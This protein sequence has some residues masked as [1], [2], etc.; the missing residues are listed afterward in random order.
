M[1]KS[2]KILI[3]SIFV[4]FVLN[5][6]TGLA[7]AE[8]SMAEYNCEPIFQVNAVEPNI[9]II[10]DNSGSMNEQAYTGNYVHGTKYYG[11]FEPYEKYTYGSNVFTRNAGGAWD[12]NFLNWLTMRRVDVARKV[13]MGGLATSR[14]GGG[15][16]TN[17]G[18]TPAQNN[19][20]FIKA[21]DDTDGVTPFAAG[22]THTYLV[23]GGNFCIDDDGDGNCDAVNTTYVIKVDK[24]MVTYPDEAPNFD[25]DG[26]L[27]GV[28]QKVSSK[29]RW[30]NEFF[31]YGTGN[32]ESGG[33]I[34]STI[35]TNMASL[36]TDLQNQACNTW[37]PLAEAYYV[38]VQYFKQEDP[39]AGLHY[40]NNAAPNANVGDDPFYNGTEFVHC[41]KG[42]VILLTDGASTMDMM[43][44]D[45]LKD[46]DNDNNDP[47]TYSDSGSDYLDDIALY[48][49]TTDLRSSTVG[50][51]ELDG[52]QNLILYT[53][54]AFG[55]DPSAENL[56]KNA[57]KNGGFID[58]NGNN[59][60][61]LQEEWDEDNDGD[62][63]TYYKA[64]N[65]YKLESEL[66]KA[67]NDIL[68]KAASGTAVSVLATSG[69]GEANLVQ[70]YFRPVVTSGTKDI[71]WVGYLQSLWVDSYGN[72]REDTVH[73]YI[74]NENEDDIIT[75]FTDPGT[76]DTMIKR[77]PAGGG[78]PVEETLEEISPLWEAGK[79]LAQ[80]NPGDR[81][82][83]TYIDINED[84]VVDQAT[85]VVGFHTG[86][87]NSIKPYLGVKDGATWGHL[88]STHNDRVD[89]VI[90]YIRG[91]EIAGLRT[92]TID[93]AVWKLGDIVHSTPVSIAKPPDNFHIIYSDE[94]YQG[95]YDANKNRETVVYVGANDGML[96]AF[97][98]G[99]YDPVL[100]KYT[101]AGAESIG[102]ELWAYIPQC[103]LPH[104]K[105]LPDP[106]YTHVYYVD[107]KP[108]I[109]DAK[110]IDQGGGVY[111]WGTILLGGLNMG[112]K[113]ISVE[114]HDFDNDGQDDDDR[115]FKSSYFC[116]DITDP[117]NPRLL[118]ERTYQN[119]GLT[120]CYPA[121]AKVGDNWFAIFGS[122][123]NGCDGEST[124]TGHI[125]VVNL[126]NGV[127]CSTGNSCIDPA[128]PPAFTDRWL[129][130]TGQSNAFM[131]SPASLDKNLNYN[132]D[133]IYI[134]ETYFSAN[135]WKGKLHKITVPWT[136]GGAYDGVDTSNYSD[137]P[138]QWTRSS[139]FDAGDSPITAA[140]ALSIDG[141][142]NAWIYVGTGRY[143]NDDDK[144][145][146][147]PQYIFGIKD[148]FY[149]P[150]HKPAPDGFFADNCYHNY[151]NSSALELDP[152][153]LLNADNYDII[154]GSRDV[155]DGAN[156]LAG[157]WEALL[158]LAREQKDGW[159]RS[160]TTSRERVIVKPSI[161]G[162]TV[163]VPSFVPNADIC[164]FGG[165]S[166]LYALYYETGTAYYKPV[167]TNG[168]EPVVK[169]GE[170]M[171]KVLDHIKLGCGMS[172]SV[173]MHA[174]REDGARTFIQQSTGVVEQFD[175]DP[176][177]NIKSGLRS[178]IEK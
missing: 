4:S 50:K 90:N 12:G 172:S 89:N 83:F 67:I 62:P 17:I 78:S 149:N 108:K 133:A 15:N 86:S 30:G 9:L 129:F 29:A 114:N 8:P 104:L 26:N 92:R 39:Q 106:G 73:D 19:R 128:V 2:Y 37:T 95:Y 36:I 134:G 100:R 142:D 127:A 56:L 59:L 58:K 94:S 164:G 5:A 70:A 118:W 163:F 125:F 102:D 6:P 105:W 178:W 145:N 82:I 157:G 72:L 131:G 153:D 173:G 97:T 27:A 34:A 68:E 16:Q 51:T 158:N 45:F 75:Y 80:R 101:S 120:T 177:L 103:L 143:F 3:L 137:N 28:L 162:G 57:A 138:L 40:P 144:T 10:L 168:T 24:D 23:D 113:D 7:A 20:D 42:F 161:L 44:P 122:G 112:G 109:F 84:G 64:D 33:Y 156:P 176:A 71:K 170:N 61:D 81:E 35:G 31:N 93:G 159:K 171:E 174:G 88:G 169:G 79:L 25:D 136:S 41:A 54:Y 107:L 32:N 147:D 43:I 69:E 76:G 91:S 21:Y 38:A 77:Y 155:W 14:Q 160:L 65:G 121:I 96:H 53:I 110:I 132:V 141:L 140:P 22:T 111:G 87:A 123:P 52:D 117:R 48:A 146:S 139:L 11:Y 152:S 116:M 165:D 63:D 148:P 99:K 119:L 166:Y 49:R 18:E 66:L 167:F 175:V 151:S 47:G 74:L 124:Q 126:I 1:R 60:P 85:E 13:L 154:E 135:Q 150:E 98:S 115:D 46:Y 55:N 130:Q